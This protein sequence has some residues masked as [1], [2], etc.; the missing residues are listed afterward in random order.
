MFC[1]GFVK[2]ACQYEA[3]FLLQNSSPSSS[4]SLVVIAVLVEKMRACTEQEQAS[5]QVLQCP[6]HLLCQVHLWILIFTLAS[7]NCRNS[8]NSIKNIFLH[9]QFSRVFSG[10][11]KSCQSLPTQGYQKWNMTFGKNDLNNFKVFVRQ[12]SYFWSQWWI[13]YVASVWCKNVIFRDSS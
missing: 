8:S 2:I 10:I 12:W 4:S 3:S 1:H 5:F 11:L 6:F 7:V 9:S 13:A